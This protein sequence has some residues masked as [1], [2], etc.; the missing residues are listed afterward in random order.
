MVS[1]W[2]EYLR[3]SKVGSGAALLEVCRYEA[4]A[5]APAREEKTPLC[6]MRSMEKR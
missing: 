6:P 3:L 2:T 4:L 5:E 1:T